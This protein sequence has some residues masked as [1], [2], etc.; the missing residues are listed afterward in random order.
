MK[1]KTQTLN[2]LMIALLCA[3]SIS[4]AY[5]QRAAGRLYIH[6]SVQSSYYLEVKGEG[7]ASTAQGLAVGNNLQ[8]PVRPGQASVRVLKANSDSGSYS[9][10]T[11]G[12]KD[13]VTMSGLRYETVHSV[14][15][16]DS[17]SDGRLFLCVVPE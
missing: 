4:S 11:S 6:G 7:Y 2:K 5:A 1:I 10:F 3:G 15:I 8:A 17:K 14:A 13:D 12:G 9:M 16:P